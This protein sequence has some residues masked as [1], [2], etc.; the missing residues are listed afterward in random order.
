MTS[1]SILLLTHCIHWL[2]SSQQIELSFNGEQEMWQCIIMRSCLQ[3]E[4]CYMYL[5]H[6]CS[7]ICK[8]SSLHA[9]SLRPA[10]AAW[11]GFHSP[12]ARWPASS[13]S[14]C[15]RRSAV[16]PRSDPLLSATSSHKSCWSGWAWWHETCTIWVWS[17]FILRHM[18]MTLLI[19]HSWFSI[20]HFIGQRLCHSTKIT[21]E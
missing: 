13:P 1:Y 12:L 10:R 5:V 4:L 21:E 16:A 18:S 8:S 3:A 14:C 7:W 9:T 15:R 11:L 19:E 17:P 6:L 2:I 20:P